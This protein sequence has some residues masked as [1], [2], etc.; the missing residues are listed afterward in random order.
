[1][2]QHLTL[3]ELADP[4]ADNVDAIMNDAWFVASPPQIGQIVEYDGIKCKVLQTYSYKAASSEFS[5]TLAIIHPPELEAPEKQD[6][7]CNSSARVQA[8]VGAMSYETRHIFVSEKTQTIFDLASVY[9]WDD[10]LEPTE[11]SSGWQIKQCYKFECED[12]PIAVLYV[13]HCIKQRVL[14]AA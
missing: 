14:V 2:Q 8:E 4:N 5:L 6:W 3:F 10:D 9:S 13:A 11:A 12:S 1:M 7:W